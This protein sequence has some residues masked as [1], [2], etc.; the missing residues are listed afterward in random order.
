MNW[1]LKMQLLFFLAMRRHVK[2]LA[3][4]FVLTIILFVSTNLGHA[5]DKTASFFDSFSVGINN[6]E[7]RQLGQKPPS[8]ANISAVVAQN[9]DP[10]VRV[11][12]P[13]KQRIEEYVELTGN[14]TPINHV[15]LVARVEGYLEQI[16]F[17]DGQIV[18]KGDLLFTIQQDQYKAQLIQAEAQVAASKAA[19]EFA[20]TEIERYSKLQKKGAAAQV[21]VDKW[22][23]DAKK[24]EANLS[25]AKAQV[26]LARLN[27]DYT[28]VRAPFDGQMSRTLLYPG[29]TVGGAGQRVVLAE[30]LQLNPIYAVV[31]LSE[32]EVI[33]IR[34]NLGAITYSKLV[35]IPV[36]VSIMDSG[37]YRYHGH[38]QYVAPAVDTKE[39]TLLVR[40]VLEN[41]DHEIM[42]G[43]FLRMRIPKGKVHQGALLVPERALLSD[44]EGRYV[45]I[46]GDNDIVEKRS[47]KLGD[48]VDNMRIISSGLK[49]TDRVVVQDLW[50]ASPG[51]KVTPKLISIE[52]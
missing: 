23:Y 36:D 35:S 3:S 39:G 20:S 42:P 2:L 16:H 45:L 27:L 40:A 9:M 26:D 51:I 41:D 47:V 11:A 14:A 21:I 13:K 43:F 50:L 22:I 52:N 37:R 49:E 12:F 28:S 1:M 4:L 38:I 44:Q 18:K 17:K 7:F 15:E 48:S 33:N 29:A 31:N 19:L 30:I 24:A 10:A 8:K 34:K 25:S 32:Q 5:A 6:P 46:I